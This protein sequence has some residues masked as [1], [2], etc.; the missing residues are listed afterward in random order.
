MATTIEQA[1]QELTDAGVQFTRRDYIDK[2]VDHQ[3]Y[4]RQFVTAEV[5]R[6][7]EH[8]IG[9]GVIVASVDPHFNDIPLQKWDALAGYR[10]SGSNVAGSPAI[11]KAAR[12]VAL[13]NMFTQ[14]E[15]NAV[16]SIA[17]SDCVC[18][19]KAGARM[20]KEGSV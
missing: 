12:L 5:V 1:R 15:A 16:P 13:A 2:G 11:G 19:L 7:L 18:I 4:Y 6:M 14:A 9:R 3:T 8:G 20:M 10:F 17:P